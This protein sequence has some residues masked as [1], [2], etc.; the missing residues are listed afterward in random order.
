MYIKYFK[1]NNVFFFKFGLTAANWNRG[2]WDRGYG[3]PTVLILLVIISIYLDGATNKIY[4]FLFF[5]FGIANLSL[6]SRLRTKTSQ[7]HTDGCICW[8]TNKTGQTPRVMSR[9]TLCRID[10]CSE[11]TRSWQRKWKTLTSVTGLVW[12][13][14]QYIDRRGFFYYSHFFLTE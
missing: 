9:K 8:Y 2:Y 6:P 14:Q 11:V 3:G 7:S 12:A 5:F 1:H 10:N 4:F 13:P